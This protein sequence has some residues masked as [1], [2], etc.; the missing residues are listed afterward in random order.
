MGTAVKSQEPCA[1]LFPE[2]VSEFQRHLQELKTSGADQGL[3]ETLIIKFEALLKAYMEGIVDQNS[4]LQVLLNR[5]GCIGLIGTVSNGRKS[6]SSSESNLQSLRDYDSNMVKLL[7]I[8]ERIDNLLELNKVLL[9]QNEQLRQK[10][11]Q[12]QASNTKIAKECAGLRE[13]HPFQFSGP[14]KK[15]PTSEQPQ[16]ISLKAAPAAPAAAAEEE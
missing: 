6:F 11:A 8:I 5:F 16:E 12:L 10:H 7:Q 13:E 15:A 1:G 9:R 2:A 14:E 3:V 4:I